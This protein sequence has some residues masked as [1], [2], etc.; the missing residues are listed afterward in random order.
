M[1]KELHGPARQSGWK[2]I[3]R[4]WISKDFQ[5]VGLGWFKDKREKYGKHI[6]Y[7]MFFV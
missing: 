7:S 3:G 1:L 5:W 4:N 6:V 2:V